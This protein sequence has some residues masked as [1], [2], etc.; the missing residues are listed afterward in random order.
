M[1]VTA[2]E[3]GSLGFETLVA[4]YVLDRTVGCVSGKPSLL[5]DGDLEAGVLGKVRGVLR[6]RGETGG[7]RCVLEGGRLWDWWKG[8]V[9]SSS[10]GGGGGGGFAF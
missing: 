5:K 1:N 9:G 3:R 7:V 2:A 10:G 4:A 8:F 6:E